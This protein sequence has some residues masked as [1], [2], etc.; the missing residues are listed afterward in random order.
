MVQLIELPTADETLDNIVAFWRPAQAVEPGRELGFD[1]RLYWGA[2]PPVR[3]TVAEVVATRLGVGGMPGQKPATP[4]RKFVIDFQGG[5]LDLLPQDAKVQAVVTAS[6]GEVRDVVARPLKESSLWRCHF[7]LVASGSQ[8]VDLRC[9]LR[10]ANGA[11][12]ETWLY[13]WSPP[14]GT[15]G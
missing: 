10:D 13:Q 15:P 3:S 5:P 1:Y 8:P 2:Q 4:L 12:S 14:P 9:Y 7:D 6:R 11:L